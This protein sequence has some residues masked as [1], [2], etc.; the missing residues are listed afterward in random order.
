[1]N[2]Q[3]SLKVPAIAGAL[4][5][6]ALLVAGFT[7]T[8][9]AHAQNAAPGAGERVIRISAKK[10]DF[11]PG[12]IVLKKGQPVVFELTSQDRIHGFRIKAMGVRADIVPG[13][14]TR[15]R[16]TP[17]KSGTFTFACDVFCGSGHEDMNGTITVTD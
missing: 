15:V 7:V 16:V 2:I 5:G 3:N 9:I 6:C 14:V 12:E 1:M 10:F 4:A 17:D 13:Q 11:T 8:N